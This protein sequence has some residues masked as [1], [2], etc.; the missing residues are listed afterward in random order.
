MTSNIAAR[1]ASRNNGRVYEGTVGK[2]MTPVV[3]VAFDKDTYKEF[4][5]TASAY[6]KNHYKTKV[7]NSIVVVY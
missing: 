4:S 5:K 1:L 7:I 3:G 2:R 6:Q